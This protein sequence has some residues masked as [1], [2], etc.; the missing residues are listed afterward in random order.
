M[1][2]ARTLGIPCV[3][4][5][6][7]DFDRLPSAGMV[8]MDGSTGEVV[9]RPEGAVLADLERRRAAY[10][11]DQAALEE[12]RDRQAVTSAGHKV[13]VA[14][15]IGG[16]EDIDAVI[17]NGGDGVGLLRS[18]FIYLN[19]PDFPT[20]EEQFQIYKQVLERL[21]PRPVVVRTLDLGSDKQAPYFGIENEDNPAM[22]YRAIRICLKEPHI[23]R[24]Q[25]RAL[26]R[27]SVYGTLDIMF[28]MIGQLEQVRQIKET[29]AQVQ[30]E[31]E[32]E[33]VPFNRDIQYGIMVETPAAA[34]MSDV[35]AEEVD[36]FS[37]GT[38]DLTQY[39]MAADRM[40]ARVSD[41]FD[42]ADPAV[43]RLIEL[44][45]KNAHAAGIWVGI[46]GESAANT[47]LTQFYMSVGIDELS[48]SP[49][50]IPAVK[51]AVLKC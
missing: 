4:G 27:A 46:C 13:L 20:E 3:V 36:F 21:A 19:S 40:N 43:L 8:A 45:A 16:L 48:V 41:L 26:L 34:I 9:P 33:G 18:E 35:L 44:T 32:A 29:V 49:A 17:A 11:A 30:R 22:G 51:R 15:N 10:L 1:I 39:T 47:A 50:S 28:P 38:N 5:M 12:Y 24:T 23:F 37:I 25:L 2:L 7:E 42:P 31:L 14:A 6:G